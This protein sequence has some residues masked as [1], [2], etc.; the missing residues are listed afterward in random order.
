MEPHARQVAP[1]AITPMQ[2]LK[3]VGRGASVELMEKLMALHERWEA[4][5]A[6]KSFMALWLRQGRN[7]RHRENRTVDFTGRTGIRT[8]YK[9]TK[10]SAARTVDPILAKHGLSYRFWTTANVNEPVS[11]TC[12]I[13]TATGTAKRNTC[14][15]PE[16]ESG[17][18]NAIQSVG[19]TITFLRRYTLKAALGLAASA[20][21]DGRAPSRRSNG[22]SA[23]ITEEQ[24]MS[25][26]DLIEAAGT[27]AQTFCRQI[28]VDD[29]S[30]IYADKFDAACA[31][32]N[33]RIRGGR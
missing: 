19:S 3:A 28:K 21:D 24:V 18:K 11:V 5:Q 20:D 30:V 33:Q 27:T 16:D 31:L 7:P 1:A 4:N 12:I 25:L 8:H 17:N 6:R 26:R 32:L 10:T 29:L 15:G 2:M 13:R 14:S 23:Y 22:R 9:R